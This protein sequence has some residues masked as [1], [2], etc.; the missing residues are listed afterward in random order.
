MRALYISHLIAHP[1][2]H[3]GV[4]VSTAPPARTHDKLMQLN[5][6]R[7]GADEHSQAR[8]RDHF[9]CSVVG[10]GLAC[11]GGVFFSLAG[12]SD[13]GLL[14]HLGPRMAIHWQALR[15]AVLD[16]IAAAQGAFDAQKDAR[17]NNFTED[18]VT[19]A[20]EDNREEPTGSLRAL[21]N[22]HQLWLKHLTYFSR[23]LI[24]YDFSLYM[25]EVFRAAIFLWTSRT[26]ALLDLFHT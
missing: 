11:G 13:E 6:V 3:P 23:Y 16:L 19:E 2:M 7:I 9:F 17:V 20:K 22:T 1:L 8:R 21:R 12:C 10:S 26:R 4:Q 5:F 14:K 15:E 25:P 24:V 18:E